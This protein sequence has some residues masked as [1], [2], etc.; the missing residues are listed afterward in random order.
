MSLHTRLAV[1]RVDNLIDGYFAGGFADLSDARLSELIALVLSRPKVARASSF[2][3]HAPLE[4]LARTALLPMVE[5]PAREA[6][7]QRLLWLGAA[8]REAGAE[9]PDPAPHCTN[10]SGT[11]AST[12]SF[13][14]V[15]GSSFSHPLIVCW[16]HG[17]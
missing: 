6:A 8:Y 17:R 10:S 12:G 2:V 9:V 16:M 15:W 13:F 1:P 3:L 11:S 5:P 7:R 4:L 14:V